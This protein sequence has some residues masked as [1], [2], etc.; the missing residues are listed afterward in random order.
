VHNIPQKRRLDLLRGGRLISRAQFTRQ[1]IF[2]HYPVLLS[3]KTSLPV[4]L[5]TSFP[6]LPVFSHYKKD[7]QKTALERSDP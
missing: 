6:T 7:K 5:F 4:T 2:S 3:V 1:Q